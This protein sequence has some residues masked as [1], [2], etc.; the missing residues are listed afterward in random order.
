MGSNPRSTVGTAT[1]ANAMLRILFSRLGK[2]HIGSPNAYSFNVPSVKG[3]GAITVQRGAKTK[4]EKATFTLLGGMCSRCEGK[5]NVIDMDLTRLPTS[6]R[7]SPRARSRSRATPPTAGRCGSSPSRVLTRQADQQVHEEG[8]PHVPLRRAEEGEDQRHQS[9]VR[10]ADPE[11][12]E[13]VPI[14]G[15]RRDATAHPCLRG[16]GGDLRPVP[17]ATHQARRRGQVVEDR[18]EEHRRHLHDAG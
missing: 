14:Q 3:A 18:R 16:A 10:G 13:V 6:S 17:S 12:P 11:D 15:R 4:T 2:P 9:D 1:D 7:R 5:G 8:A